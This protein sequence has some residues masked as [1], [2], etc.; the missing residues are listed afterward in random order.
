[1]TLQDDI[2]RKLGEI[3]TSASKF[4]GLKFG[5]KSQF[6][7]GLKLERL[8]QELAALQSLILTDPQEGNLIEITKGLT[9]T[10]KIIIAGLLLLVVT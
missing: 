8:N 4:A 6:D 9:N 7:E 1:M 5:T 10:Q 2:N 3:R